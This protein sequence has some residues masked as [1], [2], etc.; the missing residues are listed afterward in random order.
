MLDGAHFR[1]E[2]MDAAE[3]LE[4]RGTHDPATVSRARLWA[5]HGAELIDEQDSERA[6]RYL[7]ALIGTLSD[8][9]AINTQNAIGVC[10]RRLLVPLWIMALTLAW[11]VIRPVP[12]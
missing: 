3:K 4:M 11:L 2:A 6:T 12:F 8:Q 1:R 10:T 7:L 5:D 9:N